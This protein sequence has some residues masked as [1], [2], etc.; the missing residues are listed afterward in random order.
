MRQG[1]RRSVGAAVP[2]RAVGSFGEPENVEIFAISYPDGCRPDTAVAAPIEADGAVH[3][4]VIDGRVRAVHPARGIG[5]TR[6]FRGTTGGHLGACGSLET[7]PL[8]THV[9]V[10]GLDSAVAIVLGDVAVTV[11]QDNVIL[12]FR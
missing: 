9:A 12:A 8:V 1:G 10:T 6:V 5:A 4:A 2:Q 3:Y 7:I 11:A